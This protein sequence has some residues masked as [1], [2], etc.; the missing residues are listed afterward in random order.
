M[1]KRVIVA[2]D[3]SALAREAFAYAVRIA[4]T[5]GIPIL[6]LRA[7]EPTAIPP[8]LPDPA[9]GVGDVLVDPW[10][11]EESL[12]A[13][14]ERALIELPEL[15]NFAQQAGVAFEPR[16][17]ESPLLDALRELADPTDLIAVGLKGRFAG[18]RLGSAASTLVQKG[19]CPVLFASGVLRDL[20]RVLCVFDATGPSL[21]AVKWSKE[22]AEQTGWPLTVLAVS[23]ASLPL[24]ASLAR[25]QEL[26]PQ[27]QVIHYGPEGQSEAQ[28]IETAAAHTRTAL[29]VMGSS[30][31]SWAHRLLFGSTSLSVMS[32]VN[33][34]VVLVY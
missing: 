18:N 12:K 22:F 5:T 6:A 20:G 2:Y 4:Q 8:V 21:H 25:A 15:S 3:G 10:V 9:I 1:V 24:D 16:V 14:R 7:L 29:L 13:E 33:A 34:P 27:A 11:A 23:T 28:Q 30:K 17:V 32:A 26:A 19:P 31:E